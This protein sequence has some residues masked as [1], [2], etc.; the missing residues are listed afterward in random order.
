MELDLEKIKER[1]DWDFDL[2]NEFKNRGFRKE[3]C[4]TFVIDVWRG[5]V[6]V[7]LYRVA[8]N[9]SETVEIDKQPPMEMIEKALAEQGGSIKKDG[10]YNVNREIREWLEANVLS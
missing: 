4:Y 8:L 9:G 6:Q 2:K 3:A 5:V 1:L 7:M 10:I